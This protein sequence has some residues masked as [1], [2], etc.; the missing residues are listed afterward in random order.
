MQLCARRVTTMLTVILLAIVRKQLV[1]NVII[2]FALH[3]GHD[4]GFF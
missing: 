4:T 2:P 3:L 1:E